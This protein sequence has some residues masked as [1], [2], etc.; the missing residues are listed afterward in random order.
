MVSE[1]QPERRMQEWSPVH[2]SSSTP[3]RVRTTR[4]PALSAAAICGRTRR[5]RSSWH[6]ASAM[7]TFSP[8]KRLAIALR[9][10]FAI[11]LTR[12]V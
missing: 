5:W 9:S 1:G 7:I 12:Y 3:K 2:T 4:F 6:S 8:R 11:S 10:T